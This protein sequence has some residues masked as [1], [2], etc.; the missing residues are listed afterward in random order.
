[1]SLGLWS[2]ISCSKIFVIFDGRVDRYL[3]KHNFQDRIDG[4]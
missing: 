4:A 3:L 1:M 2:E